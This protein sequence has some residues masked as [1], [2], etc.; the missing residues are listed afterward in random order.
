MRLHAPQFP[1]PMVPGAEYYRF[2]RDGAGQPVLATL[3]GRPPRDVKRN[4]GTYEDVVKADRTGFS[5]IA[6][7]QGNGDIE[8]WEYPGD[9]APHSAKEGPAHSEPAPAGVAMVSGFGQFHT[10]EVDP[11]NPGKKRTPYTGIDMAGIRALVDSPQQ[12]DKA[13]ARWL[14]PSTLPTRDFKR[15]EQAGSF[16]LLWADLDKEPKPIKRVAEVIDTIT[17]GCDFEVYTSISATADRPKARVLIPL[18]Q[19]L[20]G[21]DWVVCQEVLND[22]LDSEGLITDRASERAAQLCYLPNRGQYYD[23]ASQR[24]GV[25]FDPLTHWARQIAAKRRAIEQQEITSKARKAEAEA[26]RSTLA[27]ER[28]TGGK[29]LIEAFNEC[30]TVHEI[31]VMAGY[32]QRGNSFRHPASESGSFSATV[33]DGRVHS[34]SSSD[35]LFTGGSGGG[36]HDAFSAF[37]VLWHRGDE[38]ASLTDAG[39][40]WLAIG[41]ESWSKVQRREYAQRK[42]A[43]EL[44]KVDLTAMLNPD[45]SV[46]TGQH[47]EVQHPTLPTPKLPMPDWIAALQQQKPAAK[48]EFVPAGDLVREPQPVEYLV[49]ELIEHPSLMMLFG[50]PS[51]GKSFVAISMAACVATGHPWLGRD[52]RTGTVFYL[53]GEGHAG[54]ARRLRAWEIETGVSLDGAPLFVSK[55]PAMLMDSENAQ[56]VEQAI[57]A[58]S[59]KHGPPVLIVIDTLARNMGSGDESSNADI[60]TF[61]A[62]IDGM[63]HRLG[64]TVEIVHHSG[65]METERARGASALPAAMDASFQMEDKGGQ[66]SLSQKKSK[67][68]ELADP[69][70]LKLKEVPIGWRDAK[71]REIN[72]AVIALAEGQEPATPKSKALTTRQ[73]E[74]LQSLCKAVVLQDALAAK[75]GAWVGTH[76]DSWRTEFYRVCT[77]DDKKKAFQ[78]VREDLKNRGLVRIEYD[79][80]YVGQSE[81]G[82]IAQNLTAK[83]QAAG[84][85][86]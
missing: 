72:S 74:G 77:A 79:T 68:S 82:L 65:H 85:G 19:S 73:Q 37:N 44:A 53:A 27:S 32:A 28:G 61:V 6:A 70:P 40:H 39:E 14:I 2:R 5:G 67:E 55:L 33:K 50:A 12:A 36:A 11:S 54:L 42:S 59:E 17:D 58:L 83:M 81:P 51:A 9:A 4:G 10:N 31:L 3:S 84:H 41:D 46:N 43:E 62:H 26:R 22:L 35:P 66:R 1:P 64:C 20:I 15:Q 8:G 7:C 16:W 69:I 30:Y 38:K 76:V 60:G 34:L 48:F 13:Q 78:R 24:D 80:C 57:K 25:V 52:V 86:T 47:A 71:G 45:G 23:S 75:D 56:T 29:S 21:G 49:D 18:A 63:R